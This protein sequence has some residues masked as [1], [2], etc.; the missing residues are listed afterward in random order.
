MAKLLKLSKSFSTSRS[1]SPTIWSQQESSS[2]LSPICRNSWKLDFLKGTHQF[3][4]CA[5]LL[6][7][8]LFSSR[9][10]HLL[11]QVYDHCFLQPQTFKKDFWDSV[12]HLN[13][14]FDFKAH[15]LWRTSAEP[16]GYVSTSF[17][18]CV[19]S[20]SDSILFTRCFLQL[21]HTPEP[22]LIRQSLYFFR[23]N[24]CSFVMVP[25]EL[26]LLW[27]LHFH[28]REHILLDLHP[29]PRTYLCFGQM[30]SISSFSLKKPPLIFNNSDSDF[31]LLQIENCQRCASMER[32]QHV[33]GII[34][35]GQV[36]LYIH[37]YHSVWKS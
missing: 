37:R 26:L 27:W 17:S 31:I 29:T 4:K 25:F 21:E 32:L 7:F 18:P 2:F 6:H 10:L 23:K 1:F 36:F 12:N 11:G 5:F 9:R 19:F 20:L 33:I 15:P 34:C 3:W 28:P 24:D 35:L 30:V 8:S 14:H 22:I 13:S 16:T